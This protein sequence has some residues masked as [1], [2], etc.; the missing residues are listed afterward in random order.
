MCAGGRASSAAAT[1]GC[2]GR[3]D[4]DDRAGSSDADD[5]PEELPAHTPREEERS[6]GR[7][8]PVPLLVLVSLRL[9]LALASHETYIVVAFSLP[10]ARE[11]ATVKMGCDGWKRDAW[12]RRSVDIGRSTR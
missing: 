4:C 2:D 12:C 10:S 3:R 5:N 7:A 11:M 6:D 8:R 9:G 1:A